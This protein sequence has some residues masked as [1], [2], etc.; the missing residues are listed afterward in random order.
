MW[1][2]QISAIQISY[3]FMKMILFIFIFKNLFFIFISV[4]FFNHDET[5]SQSQFQ[6]D[7]KN[8]INIAST[9]MKDCAH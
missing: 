6:R 2:K 3:C 5:R 1:I 8:K 4:A 7:E 9:L